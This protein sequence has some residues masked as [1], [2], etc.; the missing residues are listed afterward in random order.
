MHTHTHT[1]MRERTLHFHDGQLST[2]LPFEPTFEGSDDSEAIVLCS[3]SS[4]DASLRMKCTC[5]QAGR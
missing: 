4:I 5:V 2:W 1:S 3:S